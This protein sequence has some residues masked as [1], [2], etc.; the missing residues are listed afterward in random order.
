MRRKVLFGI[1]AMLACAFLAACGDSGDS[2]ATTS[3]DDSAPVGNGTLT[4]T[5]Q[6]DIDNFDPYTNQL[7]QYEWVIR[8]TVFDTLVRYDDDLSIVPGVATPEANADA[9][10]FTFALQDGVTFSDGDPMDAEA[11]IASLKAAAKSKGLYAAKLADVK[12]Y[13]APDSRTVKITLR[14]PNAAFLDGLAK[15]AI[16]AP[17]HLRDARKNPVGSGPYTFKSWTPNDS[18]VLERNDD[19][20]G[21]KPA[22]RSIVF[23]PVP[24]P[25]NALNSIY[26]GDVDVV[27]FTPTDIVAQLDGSRATAVEPPASNSM[28]Y[29]EMMGRSGALA[30]P[31]LR[32]ALAHAFDRDAVRKVAYGDRGESEWSPLPSGSWAYAQQEGYPYDLDQA[33]ALVE[34]AGA[35]GRTITLDILTGDPS[36]VK[37][38]RV[39]QESLAKVGIDLRVRVSE[40]SVWLDRYINHDYD[41]IVNGF[42]VSSDPNSFFEVIMKGHLEDQYRNPEMQRL[43]AEGVA[44]T[45]EAR[46]TEIYAQ[47]QEMMVA[48]LPV[49]AAQA[50]PLASVAGTRVDGLQI[51]PIGWPLFDGVSVDEG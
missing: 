17:R 42:N 39:W 27:G 18:V 51:N 45:D 23:K 8:N 13:E 40:L 29:V 4:V 12:S 37:M 6:G 2:T 15:I 34:E 3:G 16:V 41:M 25:Q 33:R 24:D 10:E 44:T 19:Y 11:V 30:D 43:I 36:A 49:L 14:N 47:L 7:I 46:R 50:Q 22:L 32:Q 38:A 5:M 26:A 20:W 48:D 31:K 21:P 35:S 9:T 1:L 28:L